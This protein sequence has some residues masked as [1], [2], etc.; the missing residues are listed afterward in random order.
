[1]INEL[2]YLL[3]YL[4]IA[5]Y[6]LLCA[7]LL[8]TTT[9]VLFGVQHDSRNWMWR[10]D[11]SFLSWGYGFCLTSGLLGL[12]AGISFWLEAKNAYNLILERE[13]I[14]L[15]NAETEALVRSRE[16]LDAVG[17]STYKANPSQ[18]SFYV[19]PS[20]ALPPDYDLALQPVAVAG[21]S[22]MGTG[23]P[24]QAVP[25]AVGYPPQTGYPQGGYQSHAEAE[26]DVHVDPS[27]YSA[28]AAAYQAVPTPFYAND[29]SYSG[30]PIMRYHD[31]DDSKPKKFNLIDDDIEHVQ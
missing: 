21:Y 16:M 9:A 7:V 2:L 24:Y 28:A 15:D 12:F 29:Q 30:P 3:Q 14:V 26:E 31:V 10:P 23:Y 20:F 8:I 6:L 1:M 11:L 5:L 25:A 19:Q 18:A 27:Y 17:N 13:D 4:F 22:S